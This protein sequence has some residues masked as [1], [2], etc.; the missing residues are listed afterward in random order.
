MLGGYLAPRMELDATAERSTSAAPR[1]GVVGAWAALLVVAAVLRV[2][3]GRNDLWLDEIWSILVARDV[4]SPLDVFTRL[5]HEINHYGN[6]L[7]IWLAGERGNWFGYRVPSLVAGIASVVL[8]GAIARRRG[9]PAVIATTAVTSLSYVLVLYSSEVRGYAALVFF[10][11]LYLLLLDVYLRRGD[12]RLGAALAACA[13]LGL[14]SHLGFAAVLLAAIPAV[15]CG[16]ATR[17]VARRLALCFALPMLCL[18]ALYWFDVRRIVE[19]GG[20]VATGSFIADY[21]TALAWMLGAP[22][23][24]AAQLTACVAAVVLL[25]AGLR[26]VARSDRAMALFFAGTI[27]VF[28]LALAVARG[29]PIL[30]TRHFLVPIAFGTLLL[31]FEIAALWERGRG[32]RW[33]AGAALAAFALAN[34]AHLRELVVFGRGENAS[35]LRHLVDRAPAG[36]PITVG[37]DDDFRIVHV[38]NFLRAG[39]YGG[40]RIEFQPQARWQGAGPAWLIANRDSYEPPVPRAEQIQDAEGRRFDFVQAFPAAPLAGLHWFLYRNAAR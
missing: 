25:D 31:G 33:L 8:A 16:F 32:G 23:H 30:Y 12:A 13:I 18:A 4:R 22:A 38:V 26:R 40:D 20:G 29:S 10:S 24:P 36:T 1:R 2:A 19:G 37:A 39:V 6:T 35:A 34:A 17:G 27:V 11:F 14:V 21:G 9:A 15:A 5:H 3:G 28:P 7:W